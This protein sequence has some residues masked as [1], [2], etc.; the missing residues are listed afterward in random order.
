MVLDVREPW[1]LQTASVTPE[2]FVL[3]HVPMQSLP[4]R[5]TELQATY[6]ADQ[7]IACLCHHGI[8]SQQVANYLM[9]NGFT[10]VV[11]LEGGIAAWAQE[12]DTQIAQY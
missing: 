7:P 9:R 12:L 10:H 5:L 1:E 3:L 11:N 4:A 8:R 2:G 6:A